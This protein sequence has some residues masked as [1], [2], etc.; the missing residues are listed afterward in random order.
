MN[1][2]AFAAVGNNQ[3]RL[4]VGGSQNTIDIGG[5]EHTC[6][7]GGN[8]NFIGVLGSYAFLGGG[9]NN[10]CTGADSTLVGGSSN[11]IGNGSYQPA[12]QSFLGGGNANV[13]EINSTYAVLVG[14]QSNQVTGSFASVLGGQGG[15]ARLYGQQ[16]YAAGGFAAAGDAQSHELIWRRLITGTAQT[17]LFLDGASIAAILP[18]TNTIWQGTIDIAAICSVQGNGTTPVGNSQGTTYKVTIKRIGTTTSLVGTVQEIGTMNNDPTLVGTFTID[19]NDTNESL[20]IQFTPPAT[21]GSTTVH[22]VV[23]TFRG[24][25]IQY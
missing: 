14:G 10:S 5:N 15:I 18:A 17:E 7:V 3:G 11:R 16:S 4:I 9:R 8:S 23:A 25:Q 20:R 22:R 1:T 19:A 12:T 6:I 2:I 13:I 24:L 21:A